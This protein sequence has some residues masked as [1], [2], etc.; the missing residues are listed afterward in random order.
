MKKVLSIIV[1]LII[2]IS[3]FGI[4]QKIS[5]TKTEVSQTGASSGITGDCTWILDDDGFLTISANEKPDDY[6]GESYGRMEDYTDAFY[7]RMPPYRSRTTAVIIENGVTYIGSDAFYECTKIQSINIPDSV[8]GIGY[9]AFDRCY[10]LTSI[11]IGTNV[12]NIASEAFYNC[13]SLKSVTIP[14]NVTSINVRAFGYY[15]D[16]DLQTT[17]KIDNFIICGS[18]GSVAEKYANANGFKFIT[19]D[20]SETIT[21]TEPKQCILGDIDGDGEVS[22]IDATCIQRHLAGIAVYAEG[23]GEPI[24]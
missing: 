14:N 8:T 13:T 2:V 6:L 22:I 18:T 9:R 12:T 11:I 3:A 7:N 21:P 20:N 10:A 16:Y 15:Y 17:C 19:T 24:Y 1:C 5:A 23:I 4:T